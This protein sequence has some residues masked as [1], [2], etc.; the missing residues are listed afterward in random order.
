LRRELRL[1]PAPE[2]APWR[3]DATLPADRPS[4]ALGVDDLH[5][6]ATWVEVAQ[7][8]PWRPG[9]GERA[10]AVGVVRDGLIVR[11][12]TVG[13]TSSAELLGPGD[14]LLLPR[15]DQHLLPAWR[16]HWS[17]LHRASVSW[18]NGTLEAAVRSSPQLTASLLTRAQRRIDHLA[19]CQSVAQMTRIDQRLL[20]MFWHL[21]ERWGRVT[22]DGVVVELRLTHRA[23]AGLVGARRPSVTTALGGLVRDGALARCGDGTWMLLGPPPEW[24]D[25]EPEHSPWRTSPRARGR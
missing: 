14:V 24:W 20:A 13:P 21:A 25:S 2:H 23:L 6:D 17:V 7:P 15:P 11:E 3:S 16:T 19:F 1:A 18:L 22:S 10:P 8:G 5:H 9:G 12:I 4:P